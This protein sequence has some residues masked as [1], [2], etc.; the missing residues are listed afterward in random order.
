MKNDIKYLLMLYLK[1][2]IYTRNIYKNGSSVI[3]SLW[4]SRAFDTVSL[5]PPALKPLIIIFFPSS[6]IKWANSY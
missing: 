6:D 5:M 4:K 1:N 2:K 3:G